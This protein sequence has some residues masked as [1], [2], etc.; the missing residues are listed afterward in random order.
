VVT[1]IVAARIRS[2]VVEVGNLPIRL[3]CD[4]LNFTRRIEERYSGFLSPSSDAIGEF[5]IELAPP[6]I[7]FGH[8]DVRVTWDAGHWLI[9]R[10][11]FQAWW[12]PGTARGRIQQVPS[13]Y[14]LDSVL[15]IVHTLLLA[16][17]GGF[18]LL[19]SSAIRNGRAFL[20]S[21]ASG[22]GKTTIMSLAPPGASLLADDISYLTRGEN[23]YYAFGTP[24]YYELPRPGEN[25][26]APINALYVLAKGSKNKIEPIRG[27]AAVRALLENVLF[28]ARDPELVKLV[29]ASA[30]EF[31]N[32]VP[33]HRLTFVPDASVWELILSECG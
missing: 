30:C 6:A 8:E 16:R 33:F 14:S 29:F 20:F 11:D 13:I 2:I 12:N 25:L 7:K 22:T 21:G 27:T 19:A 31:V 15:R 1:R 10:T 4:S 5:E 28:F 24:F 32:R 26:E 23:A 18:L 17:K 3:W 9:E